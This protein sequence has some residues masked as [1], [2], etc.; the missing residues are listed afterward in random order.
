MAV[1][2]AV[3]RAVGVGFQPCAITVCRLHNP[4]KNS[5]RYTE[6]PLMNSKRLFTCHQFWTRM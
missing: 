3:G 6:L 2:D 1:I 4:L 5:S